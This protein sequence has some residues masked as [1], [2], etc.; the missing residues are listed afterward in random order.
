M[1]P[2]AYAVAAAACRMAER[3]PPDGREMD[4]H[5]IVPAGGAGSRLWPLSRQGAPKF[6]IDLTGSGRSLLQSTVERLAPLAAQTL[7][8]TGADHEGAVREQVP[9]ADVVTEPSMRGTMGAI[10]LAAAIIQEKY[11]D[12]VVGSFAADHLIR[13]EEAFRAAVRSAIESARE[14]YVVTIGI[15]PEGP[16]TAYGYIRAGAGSDAAGEDAAAGAVGEDA[17]Q[18]RAARAVEAF[19]EKPD[20]ATAAEY[21]A[22]GEYFWNAGMF[23]AR[24]SVL[25]GALKRFHPEL[26]EPLRR[27][28]RAWD[29]PA[30][31]DTA[32][33]EFWEPLPSAV[34]DRA[35]AEPLAAEQ[36]VT[37]VPVEMGWSDVGDYASL[38]EVI[39]R[40]QLSGQVS[41]GGSAQQTLAI[42]APESLIFTHSKPVVVVGV[43]QA[44]VVEMEDVI[45][46]TQ[47]P[48]SQ[49]V[50]MAVDALR[51]SGLER[52][53]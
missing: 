26:A 47:T 53:R 31:R 27:L 2:D 18:G 36:G 12:V 13:D 22:T 1:E 30:A 7:I 3:W 8:V 38:A 51:E 35:I 52:L 23:V 11:G 48:A 21:V 41:P 9:G 49:Q 45:L 37:V 44:V 16:S 33:R 40:S 6:L 32:I 14:G 10:G 25:L 50:K 4:L 39:D 28:A 43:P 42:D 20:A 29:D 15:T 34:I 17:G 46:V 5:A 19:V 24:T